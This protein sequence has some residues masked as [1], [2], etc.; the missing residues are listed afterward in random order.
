MTDTEPLEPEPEHCQIC[1][2][3]VRVMAFQ[4]TGACC[5][6][7]LDTL[8]EQPEISPTRHVETHTTP[9]GTLTMHVNRPT[10]WA[11]HEWH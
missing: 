4:R 11:P 9:D 2:R 1:G 3:E 5:G 6:R 8:R 7:C 10:T